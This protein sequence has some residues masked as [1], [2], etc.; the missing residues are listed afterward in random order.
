MLLCVL[1]FIAS[2]KDEKKTSWEDREKVG[3]DA[4]PSYG[5]SV[6]L[7]LILC[8]AYFVCKRSRNMILSLIKCHEH[9]TC[10][11]CWRTITGVDE[12]RTGG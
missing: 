1:H 11:T 10:T 4:G 3:R 12:G 5:L 2:R 7:S 8:N 9:L 6:I